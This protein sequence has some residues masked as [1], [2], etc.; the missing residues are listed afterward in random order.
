MTKSKQN[1]CMKFYLLVHC[2]RKRTNSP[3]SKQSQE[4]NNFGITQSSIRSANGEW[5]LINRLLFV[6]LSEFTSSEL[7]II[8]SGITARTVKSQIKKR[9]TCTKIKS[10]E[11][12]WCTF[13]PPTFKD[14]GNNNSFNNVHDS[15]QQKQQSLFSNRKHGR[16]FPIAIAQCSKSGSSGGSGGST[17]PR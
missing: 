8:S 13:D 9:F 5:H 15:T 1:R 11:E 4:A 2:C 10:I 6:Y 14:S 12:H 3:K 16:F 17:E 7:Q